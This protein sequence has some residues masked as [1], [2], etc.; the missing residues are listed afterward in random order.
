MF[1][2]GRQSAA[3]AMKTSLQVSYNRDDRDDHERISAPL[4]WFIHTA[5]MSLVRFICDTSRKIS[6]KEPKLSSLFP[7]M[8]NCHL[9]NMFKL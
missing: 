3:S 7:R 9:P 1:Y 6:L 4:T 2:T 8:A 5:F